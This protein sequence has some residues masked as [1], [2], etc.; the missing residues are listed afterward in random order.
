MD[1][2]RVT[3]RSFVLG[4]TAAAAAL[5][6]PSWTTAAAN[7]ASGYARLMR[8]LR[9][10]TRGAVVT[11]Q[12]SGLMVAAQIWN[13]R[14][15][16][17]R[18]Y[19]VLYAVDERDVQQAV[20]WA[21]RHDIP[22]TARAGG[23]SYQGYSTINDGLI[24]DLTNMA[25]VV[26]QRGAV[27]YA[28]IGGGTALGVAYRELAPYGL[29]IP[30]G[31]C[32]TVS[33]GGLAQGGGLGWVARRWGPLSDNVQGF[34]IVTA[35]GRLREVNARSERDLF[36][37]C[38]GG[39]GGNFGVITSYD[40]R[41]HPT[42]PA[43]HF[44]LSFPWA[45]APDVVLAWQEWAHRTG[46]EMFTL[47]SLVTSAGGANPICQVSG[48]VFGDQAAL[49]AELAPF[50][51]QVTPSGRS[52][53]PASYASL[54]QYWAQC[55]HPAKEQCARRSMNPNGLI[56][57]PF[58]WGKSD[59][60]RESQPINRAAAEVMRDQIAARQAQSGGTGEIIMDSYG[61]VINEVSPTAT[62]F[63]HRDM[64]FSMQYVAYW[65]GPDQQEQSVRW[66]RRFEAGLRPHVCGQKY[67]N[68]IDSDQRGRPGVY[69]GHN[70]DRLI[71]TR[72]RF[73][74]D[75]V[76]RFRQAIPLRRPR[77]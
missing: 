38:R 29:T 25:A 57:R 12:D 26:P 9:A 14:F 76:F 16:G 19:G 34:R 49:N 28:R 13:Q 51:A 15:D 21:A 23:H 59:Y 54:V 50:L 65:T 40:I 77:G 61:G 2:P 7:R 17:R 18:P 66:L 43:T 39:G 8:E 52:I 32:P 37:A 55:T 22:I 46:P 67:V 31:T 47:C 70:L 71:D 68:Y 30:G 35:D 42:D 36:W 3:R 24:V 33:V 64:R 72:R 60:V 56:T 62:A 5:A 73:D 20:R 45:D 6:L 69:Y 48:Q 44:V 10:A 75:D 41:T 53:T 11:R 27:P 58:M 1:A 74:P 63:A 4:G